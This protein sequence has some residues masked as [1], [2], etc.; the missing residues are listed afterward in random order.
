MS[1]AGRYAPSPSGDLHVGNLRTAIL[2][3]LLAHSSGRELI[4]RVED[5][6]TA[7]TKVGA[8]QRQIEDLTA[9]GVTFDAVSRRQSERLEAYADAIATLKGQN[10]LYECFCTRRDILDAPR[11]PHT[12]PGHYPGT[13]RD[14]SEAEKRR[15]RAERPA[16]WRLRS[17]VGAHVAAHDALL[18]ELTGEVDDVVIQRNDG[19]PA[20]NLAVVVDDHAAHVDQVVRGDDLASSTP[21]QAYLREL[22]YGE[23]AHDEVEYVHVPL[24]LNAQGQRLAKRD[25]AVT[26]RSLADVGHAPER[27]RDLML[28]SLG[29]PPGPLAA[30]LD[31]FDLNA[32]PREPWVFVPPS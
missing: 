2:A 17:E 30:A 10:L 23:A 11:A 9:I 18:G 7:R 13:C 25:G 15:G 28:E 32:L 5:L 29:L 14:L 4:L 20:Y 21:R 6:D 22:L 1:G 3:W 19:A 8:E 16:A 12:P 24:V 31:A 27:V 26:L